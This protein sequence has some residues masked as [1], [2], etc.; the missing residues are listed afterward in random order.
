MAL[1]I[2]FNPCCLGL[3]IQAGLGLGFRRLQTKFQ[4]LLS[5]IS[6]SGPMG[7]WTSLDSE[8]GFNPCC[9]GLAIQAN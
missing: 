3:A 1:P 7:E 5:W 4:S 8:V 9:L 2:G 6:H